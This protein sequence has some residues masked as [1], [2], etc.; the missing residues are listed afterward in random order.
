[1]GACHQIILIYQINVNLN[2]TILIICYTYSFIAL[3][4]SLFC[5]PRLHLFDQKYS[6]NINNVK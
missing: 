2:V 5:S 3:E 6:K 4:R 1:M